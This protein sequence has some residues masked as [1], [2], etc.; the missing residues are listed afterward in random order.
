MVVRH[1]SAALSRGRTLTPEGPGSCATP[2]GFPAARRASHSAGAKLAITTPTVA[3]GIPPAPGVWLL[4]RRV[5]GRREHLRRKLLGYE[6]IMGDSGLSEEERGSRLE[7]EVPSES[8]WG[9]LL[10]IRERIELVSLEQAPE[11]TDPAVLTS[12]GLPCATAAGLLSTWF[13]RPHW[14]SNGG[15]A[16]H[17]AWGTTPETTKGTPLSRPFGLCPRQDANLRHP[18]QE[19][20][21][22]LSPPRRRRGDRD[23]AG[24][25]CLVSSV[26]VDV[27][28]G[29]RTGNLGVQHGSRCVSF[30]PSDMPHDDPDDSKHT[31]DNE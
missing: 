2:H 9:D 11:V 18:P 5:D 12:V 28:F 26:I 20:D 30:A 25:F 22:R 6:Q 21:H 27:R 15:R 8:T 1:R 16:V 17:G 31:D 10:H 19:F 29:R 13:D 24:C 14:R 23:V 7:R 3:S 4:W